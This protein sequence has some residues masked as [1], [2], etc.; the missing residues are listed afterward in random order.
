MRNSKKLKEIPEEPRAEAGSGFGRLNDGKTWQLT[1]GSLELLVDHKEWEIGGDSTSG[2][3]LHLT[4]ARR[5]ERIKNLVPLGEKACR[6]IRQSSFP[7]GGDGQPARG[8][9]APVPGEPSC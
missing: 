1:G 5:Q 7:G 8:G 3:M 9:L 2:Q 6:G 4:G